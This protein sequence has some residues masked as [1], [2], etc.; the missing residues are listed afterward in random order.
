MP[1][2]IRNAHNP[3]PDLIV[4]GSTGSVGT[5]ALDV[6]RA[7]GIRVRGVTAHRSVATVEAQVR[8]FAPDFAVLT[9]PA[10]AADLR[11]RLAD[12]A[13]TV[14]SGFE[15]ITEMLRTAETDNLLGI[16]VENSILGSA[17]LLPTMETLRAGHK[18]ALAN[19]ESLVVGGEL[20]MSLAREKGATILP[21]DSEHCAIFQCLRAGD[22]SEISRI[23]LTASGGPFF[24][25]SKEQLAGVTKA[26]TLAH[27]TWKMGEKI[28]VDSATLMNKGFELIEAVHLFGVT[29]EQV[30]VTVHRE[31]MI[32]SMVEYLDHSIIAQIS[33]PDMRHCVQY[34]L[35]HPRRLPA[36]DTLPPADLFALGRMTFARPDGDAFPLLPLAADCIRRGG[37]LPAVLNAADEVV[38]AAFLAERI[39]FSAI[40]ELI[41]RTVEDL[42]SATAAHT[43]EEIM[44]ADIAARARARAL[45]P[46]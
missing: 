37:A 30:E 12:T 29:P 1:S 22:P 13:T 21:V 36:G 16:T 33:V 4:L 38:V 6:A 15:G 17:G 19:K 32:H 24:G 26:M 35:T 39:S 34:A 31:S 5:Q 42:S 8:E 25:Y 20:V 10:A 46:V 40:P 9:D 41:A 2:T 44:A 18:L 11:A 28:T 27:P 43:Y 23:L 3:Y 14:L 45:L 7:H